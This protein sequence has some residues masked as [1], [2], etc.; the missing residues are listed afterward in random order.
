MTDRMQIGE[1]AGRAG[2]TPRAIRYYEQ[3]GLLTPAS[4]TQGGF[5]LYDEG[6]LDRVRLIHRLQELGMSLADIKT[7]VAERGRWRTGAEAAPELRRILEAQI[8]RARR[9]AERFRLIEEELR[10]AM[11]M[12]ECCED[13]PDGP[14]GGPCRACP[15]WTG[16]PE[17]PLPI[18]GLA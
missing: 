13:C 3:V 4:R 7:V 11:A 2:S 17:V 10:R 18:R 12:I 8:E 15:N 14:W 9:E 6:D 5:R 16:R 1:I